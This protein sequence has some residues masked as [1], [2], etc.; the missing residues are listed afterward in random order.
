MKEKPINSRPIA[1][2]E[3]YQCKPLGLYFTPELDQEQKEKDQN[4]NDEI[5]GYRLQL[6][7]EIENFKLKVKAHKF[8]DSNFKWMKF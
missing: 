4:D 1:I 5:K 2:N 6:F 7:E 8:N 3:G